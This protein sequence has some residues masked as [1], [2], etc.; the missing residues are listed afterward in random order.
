[1]AQ[2]QV[3]HLHSWA[4][5]SWGSSECGEVAASGKR[6]CLWLVYAR[7][8][9]AHTLPAL[10]YAVP[11]PHHPPWPPCLTSHTQAVTPS[12]ASSSSSIHLHLHQALCPGLSIMPHLLQLPLCSL[13]STL[14]SLPSAYVFQAPLSILTHMDTPYPP[15]FCR[16]QGQTDGTFWQRCC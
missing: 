3:G 2:T 6:L 15:I 14:Y 8:R 7:H 10:C 1:M 11:G 5:A 12:P 4:S 9:A 16:A 13:D